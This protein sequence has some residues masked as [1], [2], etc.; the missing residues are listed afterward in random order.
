M[1]FFQQTV[2]F[3]TNFEY[4]FK[5]LPQL[6]AVW[7]PTEQRRDRDLLL[8]EVG[9]LDNLQPGRRHERA[10]IHCKREYK[11]K[12]TLRLHSSLRLITFSENSQH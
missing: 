12:R 7:L 4:I 11:I 2:Q 9:R 5:Y 10:K 3:S 8:G 1:Y 6:F